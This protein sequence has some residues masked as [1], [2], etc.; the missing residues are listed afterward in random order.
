[1][2]EVTAAAG[3]AGAEVLARLPD[4]AEQVSRGRHAGAHG[5]R[6]GASPELLGRRH[7][8]EQIL[9]WL[10]RVILLEQIGIDDAADR[11]MKKSRSTTP[12]G[13]HRGDSGCLAAAEIKGGGL[14]PWHSDAAGYA[15]AARTPR[16]TRRD[17]MCSEPGRLGWR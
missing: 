7:W 3:K 11:A 4:F 17:V 1:M 8:I 13:G 14:I 5:G 6:T 16:C 12:L 9:T 10:L 2:A 15:L